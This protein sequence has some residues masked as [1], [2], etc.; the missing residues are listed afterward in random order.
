MPDA[1]SLSPAFM[2]VHG[3]RLDELRSL[4]ISLMRRY[5]LAPLKM[6]SPWYRA[7]A[8]PNGSSSHWP[9]TR[10]TMIPVAAVLRLPLMCNCR[11]V[12]CGNFIERS[13][14]ATKFRPSPCWIRLR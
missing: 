9:K 8:L 4:V 1:T 2:V 13:W 5:P 6:K 10:K 12:S 14:D 11:A 3:N 7:T